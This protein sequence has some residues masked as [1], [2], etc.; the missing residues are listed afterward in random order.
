[1][2][3]LPHFGGLINNIIWP[4]NV[5]LWCG[6]IRGCCI[7]RF[8]AYCTVNL[9]HKQQKTKNKCVIELWAQGICCGLNDIL[10][11]CGRTNIIIFHSR[12]T[13]QKRWRSHKELESQSSLHHELAHPVQRRAPSRWLRLCL[14]QFQQADI[15]GLQGLSHCRAKIRSDI[16]VCEGNCCESEQGW[17]REPSLTYNVE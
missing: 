9:W 3:T 10:T 13:G 14:F 12:F 2:Q 17:R 4:Q 7:K 15:A 6:N 8:T 16:G 11:I 5:L 1:M